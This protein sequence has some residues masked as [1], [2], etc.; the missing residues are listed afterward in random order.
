MKNKLHN[1]LVNSISRNCRIILKLQNEIK[2]FLAIILLCFLTIN[3]TYKLILLTKESKM[4]NKNLK[5]IEQ[6]N[7]CLQG[8]R[9]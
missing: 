1:S 3:L 2:T 7:Y 6:N 4:K 5:I 9:K 8:N